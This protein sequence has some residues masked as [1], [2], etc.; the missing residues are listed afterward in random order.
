M[1]QVNVSP[2][3]A[4]ILIYGSGLRVVGTDQNIN[5]ESGLSEVILTLAPVFLLLTVK[6]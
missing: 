4:I 1:F 6:S 5:F 3:D 2:G